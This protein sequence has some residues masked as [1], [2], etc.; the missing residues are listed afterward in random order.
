MLAHQRIELLDR[1]EGHVVLGFAEV[2][3]GA[4][5]RTRGWH[6]EAACGVERARRQHRGGHQT[7]G[8]ENTPCRRRRDWRRSPPMK[9]V[10]PRALILD[11]DGL[12]VDTEMSEYVAWKEIYEG[13]GAHLGVDDWLSAV[14]YVNGFDPRAHLEK[15]TGREY[16][17]QT[18]DAQPLA[19]FKN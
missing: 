14:G 9:S 15:L 11:F 18:V 2:D 10:E 4:R 13:E 16:D 7:E 12:I 1:R 17:W 5:V 6:G 3:V 19:V 8:R